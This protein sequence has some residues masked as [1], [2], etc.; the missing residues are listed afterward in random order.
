M[1]ARK[2]HELFFSQTKQNAG[3]TTPVN[4]NID[5]IKTANTLNQY[6]EPVQTK[7]NIDRRKW[8]EIAFW[9]GVALLVTYLLIRTPKNNTSTTNFQRRKLREKE[10]SNKGTI[11]EK[12]IYKL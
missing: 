6:S 2:V 3:G 11:H 4:Q 12:K 8:G 5:F 9:G 7:S 1:D 10:S